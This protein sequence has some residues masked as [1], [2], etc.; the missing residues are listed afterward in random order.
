MLVL[1]GIDVIAGCGRGGSS[2][3]FAIMAMVARTSMP[4]T[5]GR[6]DPTPAT[7]RPPPS[8][9]AL[10]AWRGR[11]AGLLALAVAVSGE[12]WT[13]VGVLVFALGFSA[14]RRCPSS[15]PVRRRRGTGRRARLQRHGRGW[16]N[17]LQALDDEPSLTRSIV[18]I[19]ATRRASH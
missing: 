4:A 5:P 8:D 17:G 12:P 19:W 2:F 10:R 16:R 13:A 14:W 6:R 15:R 7:P 18:S 11:L 1:L 9:G 3:M